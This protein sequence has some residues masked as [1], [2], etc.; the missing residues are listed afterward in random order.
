[1]KYWKVQNLDLIPSSHKSSI[2]SYPSISFI[3]RVAEKRTRSTQAFGQPYPAE[4]EN[5]PQNFSQKVL[6]KLEKKES[7]V[8]HSRPRLEN[9]LTREN[10]KKKHLTW[11]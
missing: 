4:Y 11:D 10:G 6:S 9:E 8:F 5:I 2:Q 3:L 7:A 1:M